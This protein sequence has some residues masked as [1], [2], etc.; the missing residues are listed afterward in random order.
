ME[1]VEPGDSRVSIPGGTLDSGDPMVPLAV[2]L[3]NQDKNCTMCVVLLG[4]GSWQ[5]HS[6]RKILE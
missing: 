4:M 5:S 6:L 1:G 3:R 2:A